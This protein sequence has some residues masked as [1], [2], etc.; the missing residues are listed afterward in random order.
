MCVWRAYVRAGVC[1]CVFEATCG[2]SQFADIPLVSQL[3]RRKRSVFLQEE[4]SACSGE[5]ERGRIEGGGHEFT[6]EFLLPFS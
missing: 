1:V 3:Q 5:R 6:T 2:G 4:M